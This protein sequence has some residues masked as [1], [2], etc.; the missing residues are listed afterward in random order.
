[1]TMTTAEHIEHIH[2]TYAALQGARRD[3]LFAVEDAIFAHNLDFDTLDFP[4]VPDD[5][6]D[7]TEEDWEAVLNYEFECDHFTVCTGV[8]VTETLGVIAGAEELTRGAA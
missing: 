8:S 5:P 7:N 1:M 3:A 6:A 2:A 4:E